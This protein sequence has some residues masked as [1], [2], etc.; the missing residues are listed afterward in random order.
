[1]KRLLLVL[2]L[3]FV[4]SGTGIALQ[5]PT[6][7]ITSVSTDGKEF[8]GAFNAA[9]DRIRLVTVFSP[10]CGHCIRGASDIAKM[11]KQEKKAKIKVLILWAPILSRDSK[12]A[13]ERATAYLQDSRSEHFWDLWNFGRQHY[14]R[15]L[16]YPEDETAWDIFVLYK[17]HLSWKQNSPEPT[18]WLQ[19]HG[20]DFGLKYSAELLHQ[21]VKMWID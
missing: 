7:T 9:S 18:V 2:L 20:L 8:I 19:D 3:V 12:L 1:M 6:L 21:H 5:G 17:P 15:Q 10:T 16:D 11:L 4:L 13:A 14:T